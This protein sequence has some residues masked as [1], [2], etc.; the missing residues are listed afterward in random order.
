M[1]RTFLSWRYLVRRRTNL[2]GIGGIFVGVA[3]LILILSIMTGFL[4]QSRST[5]RGA[6]SDIIIS[7]RTP[8]DPHRIRPP[9]DPE[10]LLE[11]VRADPRVEGAC[12][13]LNW[14]GLIGLSG[15]QAANTEIIMH[16]S[17]Y[18]DLNAVQMV[19]IDVADERTSTEFH[20]ALTREPRFGTRVADPD[21]PFAPPPEYELGGR[22]RESVIVGEQL[23]R[24]LNMR[25]GDFIQLMT[26]VPHMDRDQPATN[27]REYVVAGTF[28]STENEMDLDRVYLQRQELDDFLRT[29]R[30]YS[31]ILVKA[32]DY[33][34]HGQELRD[35]LHRRLAD[36]SL[37]AGYER[38]VVT[39]ETFQGVLIGAIE[40]ERVLMAIMLSLVL[41]VAGFT[42]F[43]ILSMMVTEK[44]RDIG[45]LT[46]LGATPRGVMGL[47]L[48]IAFWDALLG[49][50]L[51]LVAG[52]WAAIRIDDIEKWLSSTFG[53]QIFD[54]NVYIFDHIP[55]VVEPARVALIVAGAF[56]CAL[57]FAAIP[58]WKAARMNPLDALRYE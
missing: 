53:Y 19:G 30:S 13:H 57:L 15:A 28:R 24:R 16:D 36:A 33:E 6:L 10:P 4:E 5:L 22:P 25:R 42:V 31:E 14:Y 49:A 45:I 9:A 37:I 40:N 1:F 43:A 12:A 47:F 38:D 39:W 11:A 54:R 32:V 26:A 50:L 8:V 7:P 2:I 23:F 35:D 34:A 44:R 52:T 18:G 56:L 41:L 48:M 20:A 55:S 51:G 3:A 29:E 46:A 21:D 17:L 27:N 58:A